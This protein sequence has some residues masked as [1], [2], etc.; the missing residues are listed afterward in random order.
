MD[1]SR[2]RADPKTQSK[3]IFPGILYTS[4]ASLKIG[5]SLW[6]KLDG[7][8]FAKGLADVEI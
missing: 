5:N 3:Y 8:R 2:L 6:G 7:E 4:P 1:R